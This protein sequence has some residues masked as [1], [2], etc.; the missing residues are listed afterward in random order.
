MGEYDFA[1]LDLAVFPSPCFE[2]CEP[3]WPSGK[4]LAW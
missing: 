1:K 3:V 2:P 4:M